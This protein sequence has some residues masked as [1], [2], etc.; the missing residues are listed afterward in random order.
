MFKTSE[1][2]GNQ[3]L[4][5]MGL[6]GTVVSPSKW[7]AKGVTEFISAEH[8]NCSGIGKIDGI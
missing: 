6:Q 8:G 5:E 2:E 4:Q 1:L 7:E 3:R